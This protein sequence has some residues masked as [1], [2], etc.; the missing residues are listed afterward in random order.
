MS[1]TRI[2][3]FEPRVFVPDEEDGVPK[4]H[5]CADCHSCQMC[6]DT[7][8]ALCRS[9]RGKHPGLSGNFRFPMVSAHPSD[10]SGAA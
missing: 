1:F 8:C 7:R 10:P 4:K 9:Q 5:P 2:Q 6:S 3:G